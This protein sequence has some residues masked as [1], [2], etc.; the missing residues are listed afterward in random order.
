MEEIVKEEGG[1]PATIALLNGQIRVGLNK[2]ELEE[3]ADS[4]AKAVKVSSRDIPNVL[5]NVSFSINVEF[6]F[7]TFQGSIGGTTVAAT[8]K[9]ASLVGI[10]GILFTIFYL[11]NSLV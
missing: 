3:I 11:L 2:L 1:I 5:S 8:T 4:K 7:I 10:N 6:Y 9:I